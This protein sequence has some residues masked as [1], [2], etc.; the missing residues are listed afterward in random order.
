MAISETAW[1]VHLLLQGNG[2]RRLWNLHLAEG[3]QL[4]GVTLL[5]RG[6]RA[7]QSAR[8]RLGRGNRGWRDGG[9]RRG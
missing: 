9:L 4:S 7:G 8:G 3:A 5:G 1:P 6:R 2:T